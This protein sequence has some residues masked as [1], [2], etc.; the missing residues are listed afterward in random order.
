MS[1]IIPSTIPSF[2]H[3]M[4]NIDFN[5]KILAQW[6]QELLRWNDA[7]SKQTHSQNPSIKAIYWIDTR[8]SKLSLFT[9]RSHSSF[10]RSHSSFIFEP[11][12]FLKFKFGKYLIKKLEIL[13]T[14]DSSHD[15][16][17][18]VHH[19]DSNFWRI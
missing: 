10:I 9:W 16:N 3:T 11:L 1:F 2:V 19:Q 12:D 17:P 8:V 18:G 13:K 7:K 15:E 4:K 5:L 6:H 14:Q